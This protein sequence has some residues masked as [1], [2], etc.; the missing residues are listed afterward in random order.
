MSS[1]TGVLNLKIACCEFLPQNLADRTGHFRVTGPCFSF[2]TVLCQLCY[3]TVNKIRTSLRTIATRKVVESSIVFRF[4]SDGIYETRVRLK[5]NLCGTVRRL[6]R[7]QRFYIQ[8]EDHL[9]SDQVISFA[10][11]FHFEV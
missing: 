4:V 8:L 11:I 5:L 9:F 6:W 3:E 1:L 10:C 7:W 2:V